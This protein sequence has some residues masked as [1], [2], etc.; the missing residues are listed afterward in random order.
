VTSRTVSKIPLVG[1]A[2]E[3]AQKLRLLAVLAEDRFGSPCSYV[4]SQLSV[5]PVPR[6]P[7]PTSDFHR[8]QAYTRCIVIH[9][10]KTL[11]CLK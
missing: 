6:D 9:A 3:M 1:K 10:D 7:M 2:G 5:T 8:Q 4:G 11:R